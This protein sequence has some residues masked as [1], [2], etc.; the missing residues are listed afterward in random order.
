MKAQARTTLE[1]LTEKFSPD[2]LGY[3]LIAA[4]GD[5]ALAYSPASRQ[6]AVWHI[7]QG[8]IHNGNYLT[9]GCRALCKFTDRAETLMVEVSRDI[10]KRTSNMRTKR[11]WATDGW[12]FD[13]QR[14]MLNSMPGVL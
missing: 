7:A 5:Y 4:V 6:W 1:T 10:R 2:H 12:S 9:D 8:G 13:Q 11:A 3:Y 14:E